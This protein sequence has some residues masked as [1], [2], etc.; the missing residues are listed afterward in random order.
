MARALNLTECCHGESFTG[1]DPRNS[2]ARR[3][4]E[5][6]DGGCRDIGLAIAQNS[7]R[8]TDVH[9][10]RDEGWAVEVIAESS[11]ISEYRQDRQTMIS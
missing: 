6:W 4:R 2:E 5:H 11:R 8:V 10:E 7:Q 9:S 1:I 3:V